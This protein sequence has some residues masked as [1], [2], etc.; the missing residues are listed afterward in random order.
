MIVKPKVITLQPGDFMIIQAYQGKKVTSI[1][2]LEVNLILAK[3]EA[4]KI[5]NKLF[6]NKESK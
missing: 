6:N 4:D 5:I 1:A 2:N 3:I